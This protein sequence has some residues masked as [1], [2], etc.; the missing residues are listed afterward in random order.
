M[1]G[2]IRVRVLGSIVGFPSNGHH[3]NGTK[4]APTQTPQ[5]PAGLSTPRSTIPR[6]PPL[7]SSHSQSQTQTRKQR[8]RQTQ[9]GPSRSRKNGMV[10]LV[11]NGW[12]TVNYRRPGSGALGVAVPAL[13][14]AA[15]EICDPC[16]DCVWGVRCFIPARDGAL[17]SQALGSHRR[18]ADKKKR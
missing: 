10:G 16:F 13:P 12:K 4:R 11:A 14:E 17:P 6:Q 1:I 7:S 15:A 5:P 9:K 2:R 18:D 8:E 3:G